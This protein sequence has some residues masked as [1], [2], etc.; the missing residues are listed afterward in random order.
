[1]EKSK[2]YFL[3]N[4]K[5]FLN[6]DGLYSKFLELKDWQSVNC[7]G[8]ARSSDFKKD[9][10]GMHFKASVD[11]GDGVEGGYQSEVIGV[12]LQNNWQKARGK[13]GMLI[14]WEE[15]GKFPNADAAWEVARPSVEEGDIVYGTM[16]GFGTGGTK[17]A[18]FESLKKMFYDPLAY[19]I[20]PF[21]NIYDTGMS[22][23]LCGFF[24]PSYKNIAFKD[25]DGNSNEVEAKVFF[26][27]EREEA[28]KSNDPVLLPRKK[29]ENP[30]TPQEAV[31][32]TGGNI[33]LTDGLVAHKNY[34]ESKGLFRSLATQGEFYRPDGKLKF[35]VNDDLIPI[36]KFPHKDKYTNY[37]GAVLIFDAP[38][39]GKNGK[40]PSNL[41]TI[42]VD[43]YRHENTTG[44]SLGSIYVI[45][46]TN[47]ITKT[48]GDR[49]ASSYTARPET[50]EKFNEVL[51]DLAEYYNAKIA[52][53]ND[54]P[55]DV[56]GYGKR[57]KKL[58][59]L[60]EE[61][62]LAFDEKFGVSKT[63]R[64][65]GM[66]MG[67]GKE[68]LRKMQGDLYIKEWLHT[69]LF[70]D[71]EGKKYF[72][73]NFI[74]DLGLLEELVN[75]KSGG[76]FDRVSALRIG[77]YHQ[78]ELMYKEIEAQLEDVLEVDDFFTRDLFN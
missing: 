67:S 46:N 78:R 19:N 39:K 64:G 62:E 77:M 24:T 12:S 69:C 8:L 26:D 73:Y 37:K 16:V 6:K 4:E 40:V 31:L 2:S 76:N 55:G 74:Y 59:W 7:N 48:K 35:K 70:T 49:I 13:R 14:L 5:E 68:N 18:N 33:W 32:E 23:T 3:A 42:N 45:E 72:I 47:N 21:D 57:H 20:L 50:Q 56:V 66:H 27:K 41:Y 63:K 29:A 44:D 75:Y 36:H 60:S 43:T 30:Y 10:N 11:V 53:E 51:Y 52:F 17:D 15:L 28:K 54:E 58:E 65:F 38:F 61:F 34:V 9:R 25:A 71:E 1:M 22:G